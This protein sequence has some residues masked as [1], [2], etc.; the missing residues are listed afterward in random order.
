MRAGWLHGFCGV[1][2]SEMF[3]R[4]AFDA[5]IGRESFGGA[6]RREFIES[7]RFTLPDRRNRIAQYS[8]ACEKSLFL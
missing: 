6:S 8:G 4:E 5:G 3:H 1:S 7:A 2:D